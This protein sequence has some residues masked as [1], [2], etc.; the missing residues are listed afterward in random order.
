MGFFGDSGGYE[1]PTGHIWECAKRGW[2]IGWRMGWS[3]GLALGF[4]I[5]FIVI[6]ITAGVGAVGDFVRRFVATWKAF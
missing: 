2:A 3:A 5:K 1:D 4:L 6:F